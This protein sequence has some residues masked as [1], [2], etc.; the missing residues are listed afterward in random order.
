MALKSEII[1]DA[2]SQLRISGLTVTPR[3]EDQAT[4]LSRL[5]NMMS[6]MEGRNLCIGY[7]FEDTPNIGSQSGVDRK[8][9]QMLATNLA[10][11]LIPDFNKEVPQALVALASGSL[12]SA[13]SMYAADKARQTVQPSRMPRGSGNSYK[14][15]GYNRFYPEQNRTP[16]GCETNQIYL[17]D[18]QDYSESF[19]S[20]LDAETISS[21]TITPDTGVTVSNDTNSG[22]AIS[23]R[24]TA[25]SRGTT[26]ITI[27]ITTSA[28]R[29]NS[30]IIHFE[31]V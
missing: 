11:R 27:K 8:Y 26:K 2:Y 28:G 4:A 25:T 24:I 31:V 13:H 15:N 30:K 14:F 20:Y 16:A 6:E 5:E 18:V 22:T 29:I 3:P 19:D 21:Y 7:N 12:S 23:Y 17:D 10:V 9:Q 1:Q